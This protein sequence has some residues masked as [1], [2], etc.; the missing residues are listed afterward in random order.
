MLQ[1]MTSLQQLDLSENPVNAIPK[2]RDQ[3]IILTTNRLQEIDKKKVTQQE[4]SYLMQLVQRKTRH[5]IGQ[6]KK[7]EETKKGFEISGKNKQ[8]HQQ[9]DQYY[10]AVGSGASDDHF[11]S[12]I[13]ETKHVLKPRT[14]IANMSYQSNAYTKKRSVNLNSNND[15]TGVGMSH[16]PTKHVPGASSKLGGR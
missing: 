12:P 15:F 11:Y 13:D 1:T 5:V 7:Q 10:A 9:A 14:N 16:M 4:R 2:Y 6:D 3:I 8:I